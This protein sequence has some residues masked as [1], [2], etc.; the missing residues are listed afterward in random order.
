MPTTSPTVPPTDDADE[1]NASAGAGTGDDRLTVVA[2]AGII[3]AAVLVLVL[4]AVWGRGSKPSLEQEHAPQ[5]VWGS[6]YRDDKDARGVRGMAELEPDNMLPGTGIDRGQYIHIGLEERVSYLSV[7]SE[8]SAKTA[9][10]SGNLDGFGFTP[11]D[12]KAK[13]AVDVR[14][15][16]E[17]AVFGFGSPTSRRDTVGDLDMAIFAPDQST[18]TDAHGGAN[19]DQSSGFNLWT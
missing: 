18:G 11:G 7:G 15:E 19:Q 13:A 2:V 17:A 16:T 14:D 9:E 12:L 6:T 4:A 3:I 1:R 8:S 5:L 10:D